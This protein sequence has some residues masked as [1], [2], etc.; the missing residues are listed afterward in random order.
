MLEKIAGVAVV[1]KLRAI[2]LMEVDFNFH[3]KS[4]F[5]KRMMDLAR[6]HGMVPEE[7]YS[8]KGRTAEDA[9]LHQVLAYD[10]AQ[11][12]RTP[13]IV[14]SVDAAQ[15]YDRIAHSIAELS[16][17]AAKVPENSIHCMLKPIREMEF[18]IRTA[19]GESS[20]PVG[21]H[22]VKQGGCQGNG[23]APPMWQQISTTMLRAQHTAGH[24]ITVTSPISKKSCKMAGI[25]YVDDTNLWAGMEEDDDLEGAVAKA[26]DSVTCWGRSLIATGGALG[27]GKCKWSIHDMMPKEDGTWEYRR[28]KPHLSTIK[29]GEEYPGTTRVD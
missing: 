15:C 8:E 19:F 2:L 14:A 1:T 7:I 21:K 23:A 17:R 13:L 27:P 20:E 26:Q 12:K 29:E 3:N 5:G 9:V 28:C 4:I 18:F 10:I 24:G 11:Q 25:L 6:R 22:K 16:M